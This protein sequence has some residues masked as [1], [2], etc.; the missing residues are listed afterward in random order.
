MLAEKVTVWCDIWPDG[1]TGPYFFK[2]AAN[3]NVTVNGKLYRE[4]ISI[5]FCG[6]VNAPVYTDQSASI[7]ALED[8]IEAFFR[9]IPA[10]ML[11]SVCENWTKRMD[12]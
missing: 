10:E 5:F 1:I 8:N 6:C 2:D 4:M 3:R 9:E 11:E 7:N 12:H